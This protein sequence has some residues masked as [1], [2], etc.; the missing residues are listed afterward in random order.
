MWVN[1]CLDDATVARLTGVT[2]AAIATRRIRIVEQLSDEL[3]L[4]PE[5]VH[6]TLLALA[7]PTGDPGEGLGSPAQP[8]GPP[9]ATPS[10]A[11]PAP[12]R[13]R[14]VDSTPG[15]AG[16]RVAPGRSAPGGS[17]VSGRQRL[18]LGASALTFV[19]AVAVVVVL[20]LAPSGHAR[21]RGSAAAEASRPTRS[22]TSPVSAAGQT[23]VA[24][25]TA[26]QLT[27]VL[28]GPAGVSGDVTVTGHGPGL[29]LNLSVRGMPTLHGGHYELWLFRSMVNSQP[30]GA[31]SA[32][33]SHRSLR[34]SGSA[35]AYPWIDISY[36]PAGSIYHSGDSLVR[37]TNPL[38]RSSGAGG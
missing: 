9:S 10:P 36:Q 24:A 5:H 38:F 32:G 30:L 18:W 7:A 14:P 27:P 23:A 22:S 35:N 33:A 31:V 2:E 8:A 15:W 17:V 29:R 11:A 3:G 4:D 21:H 34:L 26:D 16:N 6:E 1:R 12:V 25:P 28:G 19:A 20:A 37:A 13:Q